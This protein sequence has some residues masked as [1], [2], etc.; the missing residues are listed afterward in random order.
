M[1]RNGSGTYNL[2]SNSF[3]PAVASTAISPTD[4]N[5]TAADLATALSGSISA[6]GQT[7]TTALIPFASG[8]S[9][10]DGAAATPTLTFTGD[11]NTGLYSV[12]ADQMGVATGGTLRVTFGSTNTF[13]N[14]T[15]FSAAVTC[16][17]NLTV[18]G[19][20]TLTGNVVVGN[21]SAD[22]ITVAGTATF[23]QPITT[24]Q[25]VVSGSATM[26]GPVT[27]GDSSSDALTVNATSTF[28]GPVTLPAGMAL[29]GTTTVADLTASG[30]ATF[31][32][33]VAL[34]NGLSDAITVKGA[35]RVM[36]ITTGSANTTGQV[37]FGTAAPGTL[38]IG[39]I[40]L[41][42]QA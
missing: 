21:N 30:T 5:A 35:G 20:T 11:T 8:V 32:A 26:N 6:D 14:A 2:P 19:T 37:S 27:L 16:S 22:V 29:T 1:P 42:H 28:V 24:G 41:Q 33:A 10:G 39:E 12:A 7:P 34:G 23:S 31:N 17:D 18:S 38:A 40:Y 36:Y 3:N 4:W 13:A 15:T 25:I 9:L